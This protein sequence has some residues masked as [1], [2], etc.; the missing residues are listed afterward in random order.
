MAY[1]PSTKPNLKCTIEK[2]KSLMTSTK[3]KKLIKFLRVI[4]TWDKEELC[5]NAIKEI[6]LQT[7]TIS[8]RPKNT[9]KKLNPKTSFSFNFVFFPFGKIFKP[10]NFLYYFIFILFF[11]CSFIH[12]TRPFFTFRLHNSTTNFI[13]KS[14]FFSL[15]ETD[16][17]VVFR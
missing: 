6:H 2:K 10:P 17:C 12:K 16:E 3:K 7:T 13:L 15:K 5:K 4:Q 8:I 9:K 11:T 1:A 14:I